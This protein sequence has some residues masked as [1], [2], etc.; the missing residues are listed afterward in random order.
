MCQHPV[1]TLGTWV[2]THPP[3]LCWVTSWWREYNLLCRNVFP[4]N[5]PTCDTSPH[6]TP[7]TGF[8]HGQ[9]L[10]N[11]LWYMF[12]PMF[13]TLS[14]QHSELVFLPDS[15][16]RASCPTPEKPCWRFSPDLERFLRDLAS[17]WR[18][19]VRL[20]E[21]SLAWGK[22]NEHHL[23]HHMGYIGYSFFNL[24]NS[25]SNS[26]WRS[27]SRFSSSCKIRSSVGCSPET[28][29]VLTSFHSCHALCNHTT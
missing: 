5:P 2:L 24:G 19:L 13:C 23:L 15:E 25:F 17:L 18:D 14:R 28:W 21:R 20:F 4:D 22:N 1:S 29:T 7:H 10:D 12:L 16:L 26:T 11:P 6:T 27:C 8:S 9:D 3:P